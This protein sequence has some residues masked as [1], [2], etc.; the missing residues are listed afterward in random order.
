MARRPLLISATNFLLFCSS[1][2]FLVKPNG[3]QSLSGTGCTL[4]EKD[5]MY[6]GLP[7]R[8]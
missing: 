6:P 4:A 8:M 3:S 7:P 2:N 5:G 1:V